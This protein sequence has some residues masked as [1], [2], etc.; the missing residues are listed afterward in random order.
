[1]RGFVRAYGGGSDAHTPIRTYAHTASLPRPSH[2]ERRRRMIPAA[3]AAEV[4]VDFFQEFED[5]TVRAG[6]RGGAPPRHLRLQQ[7][8]VM[9]M[10][11]GTF[12]RDAG[13]PPRL[14]LFPQ[15][16][17]PFQT[18]E[19]LQ[20]LAHL[21]RPRLAQLARGG[22]GWLRA[23]EAGDDPAAGGACQG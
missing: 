17:Q 5:L 19:L 4:A 12:L 21:A 8:R 16:V 9:S 10:E 14:R 18:L 23:V 20:E 6:A 13:L 15:E 11:R 3:E 1:E 22:R 2:R 7:L